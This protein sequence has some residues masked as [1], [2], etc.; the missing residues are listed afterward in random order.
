[1]IELLLS[2]AVESGS[3]ANADPEVH[4]VARLNWHSGMPLPDSGTQFFAVLQKTIRCAR[5][6]TQH[7]PIGFVLNLQW[8]GDRRA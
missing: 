8:W 2:Q 1:M 4:P 3:V 5:R 6:P 7:R